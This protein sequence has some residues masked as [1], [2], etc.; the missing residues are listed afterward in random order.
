VP[1]R[2]KHATIA[3]DRGNHTISWDAREA[4]MAR[5][6]Q[7]QSAARIRAAFSAVGATRP[8]RLS[9]AQRAVLLAV[10]DGWSLERSET[11]MPVELRELRIALIRDL[12]DAK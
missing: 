7:V 6:Q 10:F 12:H 8:V 2:L 3:L 9:P 4:L 11:P 1:E 5:L